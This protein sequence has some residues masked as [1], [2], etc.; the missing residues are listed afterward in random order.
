MPIAFVVGCGAAI[1]ACFREWKCSRQERAKK[2]AEKTAGALS[3][4]SSVAASSETVLDVNAES[5]SSVPSSPSA[6]TE[7][8]DIEH[9]R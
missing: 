3:Q 4:G 2:P 9:E 1:R 8:I 5:V 6:Q 7:V